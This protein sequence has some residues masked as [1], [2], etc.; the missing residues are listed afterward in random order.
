MLAEIGE[1]MSVWYASPQVNGEQRSW[2]RAILSAAGRQR[3]VDDEHYLDLATAIS[4]SGP[5]YFFLVIEALIDA[6][7]HIGLPRDMATELAVQTAVGSSLIMRE[8]S[9]H[10]AMLRNAVTSPGG[11][12]AEALFVLE[13]AGIRGT[14][15]QA[16]LAAF[17]RAQALGAEASSSS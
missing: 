8:T 9:R 14:F 5:A 12:T 6:G 2:A 16:V 10:P 15:V 13:N 1:S 17:E 3:E 7:V 4:G 11:T